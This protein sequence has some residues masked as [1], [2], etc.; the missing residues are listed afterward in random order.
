[1]DDKV[2]IS[3]IEQTIEDQDMSAWRNVSVAS[4]DS[5]Q[6]V[7][8]FA[9]D[10]NLRICIGSTEE[11]LF[12]E[13]WARNF[14]DK[15]AKRVH[16]CVYYGSSPVYQFLLIAVDGHRALLPMPKSS[17][18]LVV[19]NL[20]YSIACI[21]APNRIVFNEKFSNAGLKTPA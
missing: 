5:E 21:V 12:D 6:E 2:K 9:G 10:V 19:S 18:E 11:E 4:S 8:V 16:G 7:F 14:P 20:D 3:E 17:T 15:N 13:S 1:M